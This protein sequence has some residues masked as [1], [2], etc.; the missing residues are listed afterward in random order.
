M[1]EL[2]EPEFFFLE[3]IIRQTRAVSSE[4][5]LGQRWESW[6]LSVL[7]ILGQFWMTSPALCFAHKPNTTFWLAS[8]AYPQQLCFTAAKQQRIFK[9]WPFFE[10]EL[11]RL[12]GDDAMFFWIS[13]DVANILPQMTN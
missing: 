2:P 7:W 5:K 6:L 10:K 1:L 3:G 12:V 13:S 9:F 11:M 8:S 4:Q